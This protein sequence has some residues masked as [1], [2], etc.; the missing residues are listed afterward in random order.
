MRPGNMARSDHGGGS[1]HMLFLLVKK[2]VSSER[3]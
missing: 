2:D 3:F 1:E